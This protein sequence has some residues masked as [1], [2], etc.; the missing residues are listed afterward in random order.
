MFLKDSLRFSASLNDFSVGLF[1]CFSAEEPGGSFRIL[2]GPAQPG[3]QILYG[4]P[5]SRDSRSSGWVRCRR[6]KPINGRW[7]NPNQDVI[8]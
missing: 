8:E 3:E 2:S 6:P 7:M 1:V 5:E 4:S